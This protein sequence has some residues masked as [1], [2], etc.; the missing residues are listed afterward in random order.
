MRTGTNNQDEPVI[1]FPGTI[2]SFN[3]EDAVTSK[4]KNATKFFRVQVSVDYTPT[5]SGVVGALLWKPSYDVNK[6]S[7]KVG[8]LIELE[9]QTTGEYAERC[10]INL[11]GMAKFDLSAIGFVAEE[12]EMSEKDTLKA[13]KLV[14]DA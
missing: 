1:W 10:K 2:V 3:P 4:G 9:I 8:S 11:P 5:K 14:Q 13:E 12:E 7:F 6:D